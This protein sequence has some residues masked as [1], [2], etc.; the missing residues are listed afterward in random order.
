MSLKWQCQWNAEGRYYE[1]TKGVKIP[2][3]LF[4]S[5]KLFQDSEEEIYKQIVAATE[6]PGVKD[7]V[8]TPDV[9]T[10]YVVPVGCVM[11]TDG[12]LCQAPVGFDIGCFTGDTEVPLL[13]GKSY[14]MRDL[15][16]REEPFYVFSITDTQRVT[17]S[18]AT[19]KKT[20]ESA[21]LVRVTLDNGREIVCTPDHQFMLR[22]GSYQEAKDLAA[23]TSLMPF[24]AKQ[25]RDGYVTVQQPY[26]GRYQRVHWMVGR[27]GAL[28]AVPKFAGQRVIVHH[29]N[30]TP[31]DNRPENLEF[32]GDSD[33]LRLH[34]SIY[35]RNT[36]FHS[37]P[38]E[39]RRVA[40]L[41][42]KA[43][44]DEGHAYFAERGTR[45][46]LRYMQENP[47]HFK[48]AVAGNGERG[49]EHLVSY[50][51]S[52]KGRAKSKE[53]GNRLYTCETCGE[54]VKSGLGLHNHRRKAH[55]YN[56]K[57]VSVEALS[58]Q[59][60]VYCLTV[61]DYG[62]FALDAGVF[63]HN[64]GMLAFKSQLS[65]GKGYEE[66]LRQRFSEHR[67]ADRWDGRGQRRGARVHR[68]E[69]RGD[70]A[71]R[72]R[73]AGI[74]SAKTPSASSFR[75]ATPGTSP[76]SPLKAGTDTAWQFGRRKSL[77]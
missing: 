62:N 41:A 1:M 5:E 7:V 64:C 6:F 67:D 70:G 35:E 26:S 54:Q 23:E 53:I 52:E 30:F 13:D 44:T 58:E 33:H 27:S 25:D 43:Q 34:R 40:A 16:E 32:M 4:L 66:K 37:E 74:S 8:I 47:E 69:I 60:D 61:P 36:H 65:K 42:A 72:S 56:H 21:A 15:A 55:N 48:A 46:I 22:D 73:R 76:R 29:K 19:A 59:A 24:Y 2:V 31:T 50:N 77:H 57:V 38:F 3:R 68:K 63:V 71:S 14:P 9:H 28:G 11:A 51:T 39:A 45:N 18:K 12:T 49:K 17:V 20:R 75:S 10:G